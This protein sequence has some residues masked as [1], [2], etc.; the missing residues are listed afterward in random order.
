M[1]QIK[2][3]PCIFTSTI[4]MCLRQ[5]IIIHLQQ[6]SMSTF[7]TSRENCFKVVIGKCRNI[8][9]PESRALLEEVEDVVGGFLR[10]DFAEWA[11]AI[12]YDCDCKGNSSFVYAQGK[13]TCVQSAGVFSRCGQKQTTLY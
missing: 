13:L 5:S 1:N 3:L 8:N 6:L 4:L 12:A 10:C 7:K 9:S 11:V 2:H